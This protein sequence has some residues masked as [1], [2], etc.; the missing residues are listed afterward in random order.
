M[1]KEERC[2]RLLEIGREKGKYCANGTEI[3]R[4]LMRNDRGV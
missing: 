2:R 1:R 3:V 4:G